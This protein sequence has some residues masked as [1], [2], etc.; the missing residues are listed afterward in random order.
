MIDTDIHDCI[1]QIHDSRHKLVMEFAGAGSLALFW[2]HAVPGSSR[3][4]LEATDRYSAGSLSDLLGQVP[5]Q[6]VA[7]QTAADMAER[8]YSRAMLLSDGEPTSIGLGC[9]AAITTD[10]ERHGANRCWVAVRSRDTLATYGLTLQK[11]LRDRLG[12]EE[13]VSRVVLQALAAACHVP[14]APLALASDE[15][16]DVECVPALDPLADLL[17]G[18]V[19]QIVVHPDGRAVANE[20]VTGAVL[21]GSFNPLHAGHEQLALAAAALLGVP[22][23]FELPVVNADKPPLRYAEVRR[24]LAQFRGRYPVA[25][26]SEPLFVEKA[27]LFPGC[28][29]VLG[30]DTAIRLVDPR[31]YGGEAGRDAALSAIRSHGCRFLVAGRVDHAGHFRTLAELAIPPS[32]ADLFIA[33]PEAMFRSDLSSTAIRTAITPA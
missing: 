18:V 5:Q 29:F 19:R 20:R 24:R 4:I 23:M 26:S 27:E 15:T 7:E 32:F 31:Y 9:T 28:T 13:M 8:A 16:L 3:L 11:G 14:P 10:R 6:F 2:L 21:S 17:A 25:L 12:E 33:L 30:Y 22:A 1:N